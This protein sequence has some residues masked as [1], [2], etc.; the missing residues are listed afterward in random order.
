MSETLAIIIIGQIR[1]FDSTY[2]SFKKI[3][4][5]FKKKFINIVIFFYISCYAT[6]DWHYALIEKNTGL[7]KNDAKNIV[8][9]YEWTKDKFKNKLSDIECEYIIEFKDTFIGH[10][11]IKIQF[12]DICYVLNMITQYEISNNMSFN[13][14]F[15]TR[16]D[17]IYPDDLDNNIFETNTLYKTWDLVYTFSREIS[18][19]IETNKDIAYNNMESEVIEVENSNLPNEE[20]SK[21][22]CDI[23]HHIIPTYLKNNNIQINNIIVPSG[24]CCKIL[25]MIEF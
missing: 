14:I 20:K 1:T 12:Y 9:S 4:N 10:N 3:I 2:L 21:K 18:K 11:V 5:I 7:C 17:I 19:I 15:K 25:K 22:I 16:C 24:L 13:Y 23:K 6:Y 8:T